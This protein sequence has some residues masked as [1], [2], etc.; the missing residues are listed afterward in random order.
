MNFMKR[1]KHIIPL[2]ALAFL[3]YSC[4]DSSTGPDV[5][6]LEVSEVSLA[7]RDSG[8]E[9]AHTH[10]SGSGMNW[11]GSLPHL[12]PGEGIEVNAVFLDADGQPIPLGGEYTVQARLADGSDE[13]V[14][15]ISNHGDHVDIEAIGDGEVEVIFA[16][17][18]DGHSDFDSPA[19][20]IEVESHDDHDSKAEIS[21]VNLI[22]RD[23]GEELV[24]THG[25]GE[26]MH[27]HGGLPHLHSG[28]GIEVN[29]VFLDSD[30]EPI[31]L[32][33][34]YTVQA[35]LA[36]GAAEGVIEIENHGDHV[37]ISAIGEGEVE[38]IFALWHDDHSEFDSPSITVEVD[39]HD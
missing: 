14:I 38:I 10:G 36:E 30:G 18:H 11:H 16:L 7:D 24:H 33:E 5:D 9:F 28:E 34:D 19:I 15:E 13:G 20:A 3:I 32:G 1:L 35:R 27:W 22:D 4:S 21:R 25:T 6:D 29:V 26:D 23:S 37:D 17:W 39:D 31:T 12:H 8:E 2:F